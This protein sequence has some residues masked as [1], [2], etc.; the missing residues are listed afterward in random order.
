MSKSPPHFTFGTLLPNLLSPHQ[1]RETTVTDTPDLL[2]TWGEIRPL[3]SV[4]CSRIELE[5][6]ESIFL[7]DEDKS[8]ERINSSL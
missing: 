5:T 4:S 8:I 7:K 3:P 6:A 1:E 2:P